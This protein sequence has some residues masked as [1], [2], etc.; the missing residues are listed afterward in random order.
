MSTSYSL[1]VMQ[2][3]FILT[4]KT[5]H[6]ISF[7]LGKTDLGGEHM[8]LL[9]FQR[10]VQYED[11]EAVSEM[12]LIGLLLPAWIAATPYAEN[13]SYQIRMISKQRTPNKQDV[14][15]W[16][17]QPDADSSGSTNFT[18]IASDSPGKRR[19]CNAIVGT[20]MAD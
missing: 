18:R 19:W 12:P 17:S 5:R 14:Y 3:P 15:Q 1:S 7:I 10:E 2:V 13:R 6:L 11:P 9:N 8:V 4:K 16:V 20:S